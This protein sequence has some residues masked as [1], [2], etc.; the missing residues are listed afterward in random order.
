M[1]KRT[2]L[3]L[4]FLAPVLM[5]AGVLPA[6]SADISRSYSYFSIGGKTLGEIEEQL[7][8]RGP[9]VQ[10]TGQRHPGATRME[11]KTKITYEEDER[12]CR[13]AAVNVSVDAQVFLPRWR[14]RKRAE[15]ETA[16]IWDTLSKDIKRHEES[17]LGIA[18]RYARKIEEDVAR[19]RP[20]ASCEAL[21]ERAEKI[22][23]K[24]LNAHDAAQARFDR[25]E[26]GNFE[27]RLMRLLNYRLE[28]LE[29]GRNP[30]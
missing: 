4:T 13:I 19:L 16:L 27:W 6:A 9:E 22:T 26:S 3:T 5:A 25:I 17:H 2:T 18:K 15:P 21:Q 30:G 20:R 23:E 12:R 1:M 28:Q 8:S 10:S 7:R 14:N 24:T 11:F 29:R